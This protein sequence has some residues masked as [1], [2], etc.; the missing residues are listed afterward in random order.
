VRGVVHA[1]MALLFGLVLGGCGPSSV[2]VRALAP[3]NIDAAGASMPVK[4]RI[5]VLRDD[6]RFRAAQFSDLWVRDREVLGDDRLLDPKVV[7]VAPGMAPCAPVMKVELG[8]FPKGARFLGIMALIQHA[9]VPDR[10]RA[11][12]EVSDVDSLI[13]DVLDAAVVV[14]ADAD[15]YPEHGKRVPAPEA[16]APSTSTPESGTLP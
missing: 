5:Y 3:V 11:V 9:D 6:A 8:E 4:V 7:V 12:L 14:H 15:V 16:P 2:S 10:R 13:V 1:V